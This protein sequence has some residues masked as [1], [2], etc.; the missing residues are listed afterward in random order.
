MAC[1]GYRTSKNK[2]YRNRKTKRSL[3]IRV[4]GYKRA[5]KKVKP[6]TRKIVK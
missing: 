5:G 4:K 6:H 3:T 1:K 2:R